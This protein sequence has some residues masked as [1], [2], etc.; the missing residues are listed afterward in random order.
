MLK[1]HQAVTG[2]VTAFDGSILYLPVKLQQVRPSGDGGV[3]ETP[4][5]SDGLSGGEVQT[6]WACD[7]NLPIFRQK[8]RFCRAQHKS[9]HLSLRSNFS[10]RQSGRKLLGLCG[11]SSLKFS[12]SG[13][14]E[15][16]QQ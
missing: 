15:R 13:P 9:P 16:A 12:T 1:D 7:L 6:S 4:A 10:H 3:G 8:A 2:N 5:C 11:K 14:G